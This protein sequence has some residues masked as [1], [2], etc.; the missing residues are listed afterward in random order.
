MCTH[1]CYC[2]L[3]S[4]HAP[5]A[6]APAPAIATVPQ[7]TRLLWIYYYSYR[8]K[9]SSLRR[10]RCCTDGTLASISLRTIL[11]KSYLR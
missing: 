10:L 2:S 6:P 3:S 11:S 9:Y 7:S 1:V 4:R 8:G 5:A